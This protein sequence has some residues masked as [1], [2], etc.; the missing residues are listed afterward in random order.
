MMV[1][2]IQ[3]VHKLYGETGYSAEFPSS[4]THAKS[5]TKILEKQDVVQESLYPVIIFKY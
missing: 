1:D 2:V 4:T 5:Y 3:I